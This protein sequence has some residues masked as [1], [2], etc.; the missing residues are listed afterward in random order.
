MK[1]LLFFLLMFFLLM[2]S[3]VGFGGLAQT[4]EEK[5]IERTMEV[6]PVISAVGGQD[7]ISLN[8]ELIIAKKFFLSKNHNKNSLGNYEG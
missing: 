4:D 6:I 3:V 7:G 1:K 5:K 2:F 8:S